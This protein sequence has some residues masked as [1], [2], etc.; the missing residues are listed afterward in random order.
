MDKIAETM[1]DLGIE[2]AP[3]EPEA[4]EIIEA[5]LTQENLPAV[6]KD[7][8]VQL[9]QNVEDD[10]DFAR[11]NLRTLLEK[12]MT[13]VDGA[14][15]LARESESPRVY[16]AT[17]TFFKTLAEISTSLIDL[18][19]KVGGPVSKSEKGPASG[20]VTTNNNTI[21]V[22]SSEHLSDVIR[23]RIKEIN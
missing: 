4:T 16:E 1:N 3:A 15:S 14:I 20:N 21:F 23:S 5:P 8:K 9:K 7:F 22:G 2:V 18:N 6:V 12:G 17:S 10:Y 13:A 11:K 19:D